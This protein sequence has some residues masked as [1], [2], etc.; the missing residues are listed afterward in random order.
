RCPDTGHRTG[1]CNRRWKYINLTAKLIGTETSRVQADMV[2]GDTKAD[3]GELTMELSEKIRAKI[4]SRGPSL[5]GADFV[6]RDPLPGLIKEA[7]KLPDKPVMAVVVTEEHIASPRTNA[8]QPLDPAVETELKR[9]LT[10]A[11]FVVKDVKENELAEWANGINSDKEVTWPRGLE[12]VD[13]VVTGEAVSEFA[14]R[15]QSLVSCIARAEINV[16]SRKEG[17]IVL[18]DR[19]TSRAVDLAENIAGKTALQ[20]TG[21]QLSIPLMEYLIKGASGKPDEGKSGK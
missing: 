7:S 1:V 10:Q 19:R 2:K 13:L 18:A 17:R 16:I 11:G 14:T 9:S 4:A 12:G 21:H 15:I 8:G 3:L 20:K 6:T 5:I